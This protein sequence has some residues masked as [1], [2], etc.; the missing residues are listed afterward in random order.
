[1]KVRKLQQLLSKLDPELHV[2]CYTEDTNLVAAENQFRLLEIEEVNTTQGELVR[3]DDG[4]PYLKLGE[5]PTSRTLAT[6]VVT[7]DF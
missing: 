6:L 7:G 1:M 4:T 3:L 5:G 2:L